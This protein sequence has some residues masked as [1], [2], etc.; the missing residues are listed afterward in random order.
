M[1]TFLLDVN[2]LI[3]LIDQF[4]VHHDISHDWFKKEGSES[5]ASCPLTQNAVIRIVGNPR[6]PNSPGTPFEV[7]KIMK[8]FCELPGH[9]FFSDSLSIFDEKQ[10]NISRLLNS[11]QITDTY[12][13][14]LAS[15]KN[16]KL[17]TFDKNLITD[18]VINGDKFIYFLP[19]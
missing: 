15:S 2:V 1:T 10:I 14:A 4:H 8:K 19:T 13:L 17:A 6:Y 5:W 9:V 7:A 11:S 18:S 16:S 3:A 12:L